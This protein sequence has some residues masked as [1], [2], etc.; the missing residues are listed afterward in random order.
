M[1]PS[2]K[3]RIG[4]LKELMSQDGNAEENSLLQLKDDLVEIDQ[5]SL[6]ADINN[7]HLASMHIIQ[8]P[9]N[10]SQGQ[11]SSKPLVNKPNLSQSIAL[12]EGLIK[13]ELESAAIKLGIESE[14]LQAWIDLQIEVPAKT[15]LS[16]LRTSKAMGLDPLREEIGFIQYEDGNWQVYIT[17]DGAIKLLNRHEAFD[18][19]T[20]NQAD[21]LIEGVPE[22]VECTIYR[23]DRSLPTTAREYYLEARGEHSIWQKMPRR[24]LR[25]RAIQQCVRLCWG[26]I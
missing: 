10:P 15:I 4:V 3:K 5:S 2:P 22:W 26:V 25:N 24:I 21:N 20:F 9:S 6:G 18:G 19:I 16:L 7:P 17:V 8:M 13:K 1:K 14:E 11:V 12:F 23:K